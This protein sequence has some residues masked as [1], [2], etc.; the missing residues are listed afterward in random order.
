M[1]LFEILSASFSIGSVRKKKT[2]DL[3]FFPCGGILGRDFMPRI[4]LQEGSQ[5]FS[6]L[7]RIW[8]SRVDDSAYSRDHGAIE[9]FELTSDGK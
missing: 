5:Y 3:N 8:S 2:D 6:H 4:V 9:H 7:V 1:D